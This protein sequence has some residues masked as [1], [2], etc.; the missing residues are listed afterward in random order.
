[1]HLHPTVGALMLR[2]GRDF[3]LRAIRIPA[4]PPALMA[5]LGEAG[6][7]ALYR[8]SGLLRRQA[9]RAGMATNDVAFGLAWSGHMT[10]ARLLRLLAVLPDGVSE[11]YFHPAAGRDPTIDATMPDYEH[12]AELAGLLSPAVRAALDG[13]GA[14]LSAYG[15]L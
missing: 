5:A 2:I 1:M 9:R 7:R 4:E 12:E 13:S 6:G 3:G 14:V 10:E 8:W 15:G 11:I